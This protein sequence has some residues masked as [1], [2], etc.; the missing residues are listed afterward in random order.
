MYNKLPGKY[1]FL[2]DIFSEARLQALES[3]AMQQ[4]QDILSDQFQFSQQ[5]WW[6]HNTLPVHCSTCVLVLA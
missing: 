6:L 1:A 3:E 5:L 4:L 2:C